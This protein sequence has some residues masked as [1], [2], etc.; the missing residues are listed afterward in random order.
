MIT[1]RAAMTLFQGSVIFH[2]KL[3]SLF[4]T[5]PLAN[6]YQS[7]F[8]QPALPWTHNL[9]AGGRLHH[10]PELL[11]VAELVRIFQVDDLPVFPVLLVTL[12]VGAV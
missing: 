11:V 1:P 7:H 8:S 6:R 10:I 9:T 3:S 12:F 5:S 4:S 2:P